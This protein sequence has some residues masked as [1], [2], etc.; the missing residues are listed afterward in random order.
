MT[1]WDNVGDPL[2][3]SMHLPD[4]LYPVSFQRCRPLKLPLS[5]KIVE[6]GSF[7][8][9]FVGGYAPHFGHAF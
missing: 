3:L 7:G 8:S 9:Q 5:C 1:F 6:K 2:W 4:C